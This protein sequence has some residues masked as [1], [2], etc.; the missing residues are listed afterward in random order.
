MAK[1]K[2]ISAL[3]VNNTIQIFYGDVNLNIQRTQNE[4]LFERVFKMIESGNM[5]ELKKNFSDIKAELERYTKGVFHVKD[6]A[7]H[8]KGDDE[9]I[10][11]L[12]AKKLVQFRDAKEDF[13]PL[14]R[15]WKKLKENP[16]KRL[17]DQLYGFMVHNNIPITN[18]GDVICEKGVKEMTDG[19]LVDQR[20]GEFDNSI[21]MIVQAP[22]EGMNTDP[23][24]TCAAGLHVAAPDFV[25][26]H[27]SS[28][29]IIECLVSPADFVAIPIDY[30]NTKARVCRYQVLGLAKKEVRK[31]LLYNFDDIVVPTH[32]AIDEQK[33][34][35]TYSPSEAQDHGSK[36]A[37]H[38][39]FTKMTARAIVE[40]VNKTYGIVITRDLKNKQ[41]IIK[42]AE[43]C[44]LSRKKLE[45]RKVKN[46]PW[47]TYVRDMKVFGVSAHNFS[48]LEIKNFVYLTYSIVEYPQHAEAVGKIQQIN[49]KN[50][51][52][53]IKEAYKLIT[54][55]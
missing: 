2:D 8:L 14:V 41:S 5:E 30:N 20:T 6:G 37:D 24:V 34:R 32:G 26:N 50:K 19:K 52:Q 16:D 38:V 7:M 55:K 25:R 45:S 40:Y 13:M 28:G 15:F 9:P 42:D 31:E 23:N 53:I 21:G 43:K 39:D 17:R 22:R 11:A 36:N 3:A 35:S 49:S 48:A 27:W 29:I 47:M 46:A 18:L 33:S 4:P 51:A 12:I 44:E 54:K 1:K 10:P